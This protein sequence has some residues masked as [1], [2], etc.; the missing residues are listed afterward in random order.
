[1]NF[2]CFLKNHYIKT[3]LVSQYDLVQGH[4]IIISDRYLTVNLMVICP[5]F[6][7]DI[8]IWGELAHLQF[9]FRL[10]QSGCLISHHIQTKPFLDAPLLC[11]L[12]GYLN[13]VII[14]FFFFFWS[15][16]QTF[17]VGVA[18][19]PTSTTKLKTCSERWVITRNKVSTLCLYLTDFLF[20]SYIVLM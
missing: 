6:K 1:M 19:L 7:V 16:L 8:C 17:L 9:L 3:V 18:L 15:C 10:K 13:V 11:C 20:C 14:I 12:G 5:R 4:L 2:L